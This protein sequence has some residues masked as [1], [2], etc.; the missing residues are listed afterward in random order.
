MVIAFTIKMIP[1]P[2][3]ASEC[4]VLNNDNSYLNYSQL[5]QIRFGFQIN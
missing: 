3:K 5:L 4:G 2:V 1:P